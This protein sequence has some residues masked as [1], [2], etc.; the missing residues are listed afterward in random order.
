MKILSKLKETTLSVLPIVVIVLILHLTIAPIGWDTFWGFVVGAL[1]LIAG[2][3]LFL[4]GVDVAIIPVGE[5]VGNRLMARRNLVL[6]LGAALVIGTVGTIAE[7]DVLVLAN[8]VASVDNSIPRFPLILMVSLGMGLMLAVG[9]ARIVFRWPYRW[10]LVIFFGII[11]ILLLFAQEQHLAIAFDA[12]GMA[13]GPLVVPFLMAI[14]IGVASSRSVQNVQDDSFGLIGLGTIGPVLALLILSI[15]TPPADAQNIQAVTLDLSG[16][17]FGPSLS[18]LLASTVEQVVWALFPLAIIFLIFHFTLLKLTK[19]QL[20][21]LILG[22]TYAFFGLILFLVGVN[23]AFVPVGRMLGYLSAKNHSPIILVTVAL[24]LGSVVVLAEPSVWVLADQV[25]ELSSGRVSRKTLLV[26]M[27]I[28][29]SLAAGLSMLRVVLAFDFR[30]FIIPGYLL[31]ITL[32]FFS[33]K[34]FT[35][36]GF[37]SGTVTSGPMSCTFILALFLGASHALG[38]NPTTDAFGL[39]AMVVLVPILT[40][41][42]LGVM[43]KAKERRLGRPN[44]EEVQP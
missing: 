24:V 29:V 1:I 22:L 5:R 7:P 10:I 9:I 19:S 31:A 42:I 37:D 16:E 17:L 6:L 36:I 38:G 11:G 2:L 3:S 26:S 23:G 14:G 18:V 28:G 12:G 35:A 15:V 13:T 34:L 30:Y 32:S 44:V 4:V 43:V 33:P 39:V 27:S 21:R 8:Q 20:L 41:E 40:V 25:T